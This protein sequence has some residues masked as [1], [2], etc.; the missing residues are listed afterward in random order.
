MYYDVETKAILLPKMNKILYLQSQLKKKLSSLKSLR[1]LHFS[2]FSHEIFRIGVKL[3]FDLD[4][5]LL[6][7]ILAFNKFGCQIMNFARL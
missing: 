6:F 4:L 2:I 3:N 1:L 5:L 7:L